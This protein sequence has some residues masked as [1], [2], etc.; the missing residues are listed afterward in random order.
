MAY[1]IAYTRTTECN[2]DSI[3]AL[4]HYL[5][6]AVEVKTFDS[7]IKSGEE[8]DILTEK[9]VWELFQVVIYMTMKQLRV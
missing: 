2:R 3:F 6:N 8:D 1:F 7:R 5:D 9:M 4:L